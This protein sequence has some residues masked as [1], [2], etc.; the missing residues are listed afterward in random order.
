MSPKIDMRDFRYFLYGFY[1]IS[2][3][4]KIDDKRSIL[5]NAFSRAFFPINHVILRKYGR[6]FVDLSK[7]VKGFY[8]R[9]PVGVFRCPAGNYVLQFRPKR[10]PVVYEHLKKM[11]H[12]VFLDVGAS[13]GFYT[14]LMSRLLGKR[15][16]V[17]AFEPHPQLFEIL[18]ENLELNHC[19]NVIALNLACWYRPQKLTLYEHVS[20]NRVDHSVVFKNPGRQIEIDADSLDNI[21]TKINVGNVDL[22]K[23]DV[24]GSAPQVFMGMKKVLEKNRTKII[25]ECLSMKEFEICKSTLVGRYTI[26][27]IGDG[28]YIAVPY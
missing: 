16:H 25:F 19:E 28:N 24:E 12:G 3:G 4:L 22:M 11:R 23:I 8:C 7:F 5:L 27:N 26:E 6:V 13:I 18:K 2:Y 15:G 9:T 17:V 21:L 10:E 1:L 20:G 14:V